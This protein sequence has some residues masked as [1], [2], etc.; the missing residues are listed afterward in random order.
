MSIISKK[1]G[2]L[3]EKDIYAYTLDNCRGLSAEI[4]NYGAILTRLVY[5]KTDVVL[6][7]NGFDEYIDNPNYLVAIIGRN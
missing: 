4:I 1:Y 6:G 3:K 2:E 7:Y 5:N